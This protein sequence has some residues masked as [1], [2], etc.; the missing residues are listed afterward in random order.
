MILSIFEGQSTPFLIAQTFGLMAFF[1][2][3]YAGQVKTGRQVMTFYGL[4][5]L[6]WVGHYIFLFANLA[7]FIN[8]V[9]AGRL[10]LCARVKQKYVKHVIIWSTI[11]MIAAS[12]IT[13][14]A[15][16]SLIPVMG[17][18]VFTLSLLYRDSAVIVRIGGFVCFVSWCIHGYFTGSYVEFFANMF[19]VSTIIYGTLKHDFGLLKSKN[20]AATA[21]ISTS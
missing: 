2:Q 10:L 6:I 18:V 1:V 11:A 14:E 9:A 5:N 16:Y 21:P 3:L 15:Y 17:S 13:Y 4:S 20:T 12:F 8:L 19:C 7:A